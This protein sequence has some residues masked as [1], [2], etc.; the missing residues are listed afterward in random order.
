[1]TVAVTTSKVLYAPGAPTTGPFTFSFEIYD[2]TDLRV[3]KRS[4]TGIDTLLAMTTDYTVS[5]GPWPSGG[6]VTTIV[7]VAVG[8]KL[9][10]K[11]NLDAT[12]G[13][14]LPTAGIFPA[15][16]VEQALD[17]NVKLIQQ[18]TETVARCV[19]FQET[20]AI[21]P[22]T[23]ADPTA[24]GDVLVYDGTG[25]S[26]AQLSSY[27]PSSV[28]TGAA[29]RELMVAATQSDA[30]IVMGSRFAG[31][32]NIGISASAATGALTLSLT[33][34]DG[35]ALG[36]SNKG[37]MSIFAGASSPERFANVELTSS[38][39]ITIPSTA[40]LG[41]VA[42]T[43]FRVW[44]VGLM[45]GATFKLGVFNPLR[46]TGNFAPFATNSLDNTFDVYPLEAYGYTDAQA[47]LDTGADSAGTL[48][49]VGSSGTFRAYSILGYVEFPAG[50]V[51]PGT[52]VAPSKTRVWAAGMPTPGQVVRSFGTRAAAVL[53]GATI[54]PI[55]DTI[56]QISEGVALMTATQG[57]SAFESSQCNLLRVQARAC[58]AHD[59]AN[60]YVG[61]ALFLNSQANACAAALA[62]RRATA[63]DFFSPLVVD[64]IGPNID[65]SGQIVDSVSMRAGSSSAG[66]LTFNGFSSGRLFGGRMASQIICEEVMT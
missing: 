13:K 39:S 18:V 11:L 63:N 49:Y 32:S 8:E 28:V 14:D 50:L 3:V 55:D 26:F 24:T 17:R 6:T 19:Q 36:A 27:S 44:L 41:A 66:T 21:S 45:A 65:A 1:M 59:N 61:G 12:Q 34:W 43:P 58:L 46:V 23:P 16:D 31:N 2:D 7:A 53:T 25:V 29:G 52:W 5:A 42:N 30:K 64:Y 47:E 37:F 9:L 15:E 54:M 35:S 4:A 56:P 57:L 33:G 48:Y 62:N 60:V 22:I 38:Q 20:T 40:L 51:T 10:I